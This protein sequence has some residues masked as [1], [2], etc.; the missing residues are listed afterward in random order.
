MKTTSSVGYDVT[1]YSTFSFWRIP[2]HDIEK[3]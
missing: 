3:G 2:N 1:F